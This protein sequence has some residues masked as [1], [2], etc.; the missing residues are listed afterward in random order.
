M[1]VPEAAPLG[2]QRAPGTGTESA[3]GNLCFPKKAQLSNCSTVKYTLLSVLIE[4]ST[5]KRL[6]HVSDAASFN[7]ILNE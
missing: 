1:T 2:L 3:I 7:P 4:L 5:K 6:F